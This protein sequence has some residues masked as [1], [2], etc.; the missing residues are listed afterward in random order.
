MQKQNR[1]NITNFHNNYW[2]SLIYSETKGGQSQQ[3]EYCVTLFSQNKSSTHALMIIY[4][5][6]ATTIIAMLMTI[7]PTI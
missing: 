3:S 2:I 7:N 6:E 1:K 5:I 4:I